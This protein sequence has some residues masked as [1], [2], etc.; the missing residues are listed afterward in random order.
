MR[1]M[2]SESSDELL[3]GENIRSKMNPEAAKKMNES[4]AQP[5]NPTS[6]KPVTDSGV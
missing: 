4:L 6:I 1:R 2:F 3:F 5:D